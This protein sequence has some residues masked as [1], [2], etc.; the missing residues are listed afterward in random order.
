MPVFIDT[1]AVLAVLNAND[2][3]HGSARETWLRLMGGNELLVTTNYIL[4][5][6]NA[7]LQHHIGLD[8][9]HLC[10]ND[11]LPVLIIQWIGKEV[12]EREVSVLY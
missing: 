5:E 11:V 2:N 1:S 8:A 12:H 9:V 3:F 6:T 7:I 4:L 10:N